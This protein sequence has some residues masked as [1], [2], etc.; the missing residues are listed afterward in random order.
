MIENELKMGSKM[1]RKWAEN[2]PKMSR[3]W[4]PW[5]T[6]LKGNSSERW[7][8]VIFD[9]RVLEQ[10][11][12]SL[13]DHIFSAG[14]HRS[15]PARRSLPRNESVSATRVS[16]YWLPCRSG[17]EKDG[18]ILY[19]KWRELEAGLGGTQFGLGRKTHLSIMHQLQHWLNRV[20]R[21]V[22]TY[23]TLYRLLTV[24]SKIQ[25]EWIVSG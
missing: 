25:I 22:C 5:T 4:L 6:L 11:R 21:E 14:G 10:E 9:S 13:P 18:R 16:T 2:E 24:I 15:S 12:L 1:S 3:K 8:W 19:I 23:S 20:I 17:R 7:S